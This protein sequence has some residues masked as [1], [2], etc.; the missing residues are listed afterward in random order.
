MKYLLLG[1]GISNKSIKNYFDENN[2]EYLVYDDNSCNVEIDFN[3]V[4]L[5]IKS[6]GIEN[7]HPFLN[8]GI[9]VVTDLEMFYLLTENRNF[10]TVTGANGK[11][12]TVSLIN[13]LI[14]DMDLAGNIGYPLFDF[15]YSKNDVI[16]EA[17]SFMLEYIDKFRSKYNIILN[18]Y[19]THLEHHHTYA[20][21]VKSKL[22]LLKNI[23]K[24]DYLIYNY[25]DVLLRRL[26]EVYDC[27]KIPISIKHQVGLHIKDNKII[28][29]G[30]VI[31]TI[32][33]IKLLGNHNLI[34]VLCAIA[35]IMNYRGD[36][37]RLSLFSGVKYRLQYVGMIGNVRV[38]NDSKST[39]YNALS[40]AIK[41]FNNNIL[42]ICGGMKREDSLKS[43]ENLEKL[44]RVYCYGSNRFEF[45]EFFKANNI[46]V[47][48]FETLDELINNLDYKNIDVLLFSPGSVSYDQFD[49]Y[50]YRGEVFNK[51]ISK[52]F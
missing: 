15:M 33:N 13:H 47:Y 18:L 9:K 34:N 20:N 17:S 4:S 32:N 12:T 50:I 29:D 31:E 28:Y 39:N 45:E 37:K 44:K 7:T 19:K 40:S 23:K 38:F 1:L 36:L 24:D 5:I 43:L 30:K 42:L 3:E 14:D 27:I 8:K 6:P 11:T 51:L 41:S 48:S 49:N 2:I 35:V 52:Y 10:I 46:E 22:N 26:V 25:D 16:I 21:Y